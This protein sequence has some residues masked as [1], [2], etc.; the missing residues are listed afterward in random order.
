MATVGVKG[1]NRQLF[2]LCITVQL[3]RN[4]LP[5][6]GASITDEAI[7]DSEDEIA[8]DS[9]TDVVTVADLHNTNN[10]HYNIYH[11]AIT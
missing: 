5:E 7:I 9:E 6:F 11:V 8:V 1:L 3:L 2:T 10:K 4:V